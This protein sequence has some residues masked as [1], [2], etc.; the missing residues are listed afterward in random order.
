MPGDEKKTAIVA[1]CGKGGAG[2]TVISAAITR[3]LLE[4][5]GIKV[6][7]VDADPAAGL[8][9]PLGVTVRKT[10]DDVR[11]RLIG[12]MEGGMGGDRADIVSRLDYEVFDAV[13]ERGN[14]AFLAIGR[15]ETEGC[16]CRVNEIL[17]DV[18]GAVA[19][20]FD[21]VVIDGEAGIEQVN[22]RVMERVT[23]LLFISDPSRRGINVAKTLLEVSRS[24]VSFEESGLI[25]N[26]A[27]GGEE[28]ERL[29]IP[30][31]LRYLGWVP[32]DDTIREHDIR[33]K[34]IFDLPEGPL[35]AAVRN[36]LRRLMA[37]G[38][39]LLPPFPGLG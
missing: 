29:I 22:R 14:L 17:K 39:G 25:V 10:V 28:V 38:A 36:C 8:A 11:N 26:R 23:H 34:T 18:I 1:V 7:A 5:P 21:F 31:G 33:G 15:P 19:R 37:P 9:S 6:L 24:A 13:E 12:E 27:R 2:K 30:E 16:Y 32:E 20:N 35:L 3:I 4:R